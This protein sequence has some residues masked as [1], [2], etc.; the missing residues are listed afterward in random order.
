MSWSGASVEQAQR[1]AGRFGD[2]RATAPQASSGFAVAGD[3]ADFE[4]RCPSAR[5]G[6]QR[7]AIPEPRRRLCRGMISANPPDEVTM[8]IRRPVGSLLALTK[9]P[10]LSEFGEVRHPRS[11]DG[12]CNSGRGSFRSAPPIPRRYGSTRGAA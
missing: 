3:E 5:R 12:A 2:K 8:P 6:R 4:Q 1:L 7:R 11:H 10:A 9:P